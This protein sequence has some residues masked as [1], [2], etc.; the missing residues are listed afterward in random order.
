MHDRPNAESPIHVQHPDP[1]SKLQTGNRNLKFELPDF[2]FI[3]SQNSEVAAHTSCLGV[4]VLDLGSNVSD[5][6]LRPV[7]YILV[8]DI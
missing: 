4:D 8:F 6:R 5:F 7:M 3:S 1:T 2:M